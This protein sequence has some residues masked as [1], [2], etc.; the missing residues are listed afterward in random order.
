[1]SLQFTLCDL[2]I[3]KYLSEEQ[4]QKMKSQKSNFHLWDDK[5]KKMKEYLAE[6]GFTNV[7]MWEQM[8]NNN[9]YKD[10]ADFMR[11]GGKSRI[12]RTVSSLGLSED[13]I[14]KIAEE[15]AALYD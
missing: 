4:K 3:E 7:K 10:G 14:E 12:K 5:G 15:G 2:A 8:L 6:A 13:L 9:S 1:M 11:Q